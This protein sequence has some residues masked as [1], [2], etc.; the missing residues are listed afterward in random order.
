MK[1]LSIYAA[2]LVLLFLGMTSCNNEDEV[3]TSSQM[4]AQVD[5]AQ[6]SAAQVT[7]T[8][9]DTLGASVL[10]IAGTD[11]RGNVLL[12]NV[13]PQ[14]RTHRLDTITTASVLYRPLVGTQA[15]S[16]LC[17]SNPEGSITVTS[18]DTDNKRVSLN[19]DAKLCNTVGGTRRVTQGQVNNLNY[20]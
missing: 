9:Q 20:R 4:T 18:L 3:G 15:I 10:I 8:L 17:L 2:A 19:F 7:G 1:Q 12:I 16:N 13:P 14:E 6:W 11:V 5:G